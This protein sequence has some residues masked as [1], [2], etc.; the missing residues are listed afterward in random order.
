LSVVLLAGA[1]LVMRSVHNLHPISMGYDSLNLVVAPIELEE[2]QYDRAR[3]QD[4]YL[5]LAERARALPGARAVTFVDHALIGFGR[6]RSSVGIEGYQP[7]P[8]EDMQLDRN[9]IGPGYLTAMNIP[10]TQG[11]DFDER[12]RDG[13]AGDEVGCDGRT[14][15]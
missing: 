4:F 8:G 10:I 6:S 14:A 9:I 11:R 2:R 13:A 5:R 7:G 15:L 3:S 12:D 1:G